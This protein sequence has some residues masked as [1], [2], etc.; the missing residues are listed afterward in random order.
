VRGVLDVEYGEPGSGLVI[1][2]EVF[3]RVPLRERITL[4]LLHRVCVEARPKHAIEMLRRLTALSD[5]EREVIKRFVG[6]EKNVSSEEEQ[7]PER[8]FLIPVLDTSTF[9][10]T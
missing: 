5:E 8:Q 2:V 1:P 4:E 7:A 6:V 3:K 9:N 10:A